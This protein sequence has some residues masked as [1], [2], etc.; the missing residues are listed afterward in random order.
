MAARLN[1]KGEV[2]VL[3]LSPW[4]MIATFADKSLDER[5][6]QNDHNYGRPKR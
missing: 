3:Q 5:L 4:I 2:A 1:K 6:L